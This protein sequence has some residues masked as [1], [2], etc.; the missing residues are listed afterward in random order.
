MSAEE[1]DKVLKDWRRF[2]ESD[3]NKFKFTKALYNHLIQHCSFIAHYNQAGFYGTYFED[4]EDTIRF[5]KQFDREHECLSVEYGMTYWITG[6]DYQ[7]INTAMV[8]VMEPYKSDLY[9]R[10]KQK[11][12][13][14]K[15]KQIKGLQNC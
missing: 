6:A 4:P 8:E 1:K 14:I 11:A 9:P 12:K 10:L 7:D 2:I 13:E 5:M 15:L 3:F